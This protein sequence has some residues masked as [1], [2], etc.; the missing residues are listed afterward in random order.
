MPT[1]RKGREKTPRVTSENT[2]GEIFITP[3]ELL[4]SGCP[5]EL[6]LWEKTRDPRKNEE[7]PT[8]G[9]HRMETRKQAWVEIS[10]FPFRKQSSQLK[11]KQ[12]MGDHV[13]KLFL[14]KGANVRTYK[15]LTKFSDT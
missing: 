10:G 11:E 12:R 5:F 13:C 14:W 3:W 8:A 6:S 2:W 7:K 1:E 15:Q 9:R 4:G